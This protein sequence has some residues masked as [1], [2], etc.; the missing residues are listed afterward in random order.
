[1][2]LNNFR[3]QF[4]FMNDLSNEL[5]VPECTYFKQS[6]KKGRLAKDKQINL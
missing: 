2:Y 4:I 3:F 6:Q 5:D 1:M